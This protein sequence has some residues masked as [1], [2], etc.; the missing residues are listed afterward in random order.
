MKPVS[1]SEQTRVR[2]SN[3][4]RVVHLFDARQHPWYAPVQRAVGSAAPNC[5]QGITTKH[6]SNKN[7]FEW[8]AD[9]APF[10]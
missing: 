6:T 3:F 2:P 7:A 8:D 9:N 1:M 10:S 4:P 5:E